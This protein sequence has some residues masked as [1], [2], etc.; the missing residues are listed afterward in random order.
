MRLRRVSSASGRSS[1][2][3][4]CRARAPASGRHRR[5]VRA[6][7]AA[8]CLI[9]SSVDQ[10][11]ARFGVRRPHARR[12]RAPRLSRAPIGAGV[13]GRLEVARGFRAR[14]SAP[15]RRSGAIAAGLC[16][17]VA[18]RTVSNCAFLRREQMS[19]ARGQPLQAAE[20]RVVLARPDAPSWRTP[21]S[22]RSRASP[23]PVDVAFSS[24]LRGDHRS[25]RAMA[26]NGAPSC[27]SAC[28]APASSP[29]RLLPVESGCRGS[30][31]GLSW[32]IALHIRRSASELAGESAFRQVDAQ[33]VLSYRP[34]HVR[35]GSST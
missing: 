35:G 13:L 26:E 4:R 9:A 31:T 34:C 21:S 20:L 28:S 16:L 2:S 17:R 23:L 11:L 5:P 12:P 7:G 14:R 27:A 19:H 24:P 18:P 25:V 1:F 22:L 6:V 8:C 3:Y 10:R 15:Q 29:S 33:C 30:L 32:S